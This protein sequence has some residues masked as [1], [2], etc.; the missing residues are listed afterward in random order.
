VYPSAVRLLAAGL[1]A[2]SRG[3]LPLILV[4]LVISN[5]PITPAIVLRLFVLFTLIPASIAW[6]MERGADA[7]V[8]LRAGTLIARRKRSMVEV[9]CSTIAKIEPWSVPFPG[10]GFSLRM[11]SGGRLRHVF[12][13]ADPKPLLYELADRG[14]VESAHAAVRHPV[15]EWAHAKAVVGKSFWDRAV[16]KFVAFALVPATIVFYTKQRISYGSFLGEYYASGLGEW[17]ATFLLHWIT[18]SVYLVLYASLLRGVAESF[19]LAAASVAPLSAIG[20]RR[21]VEL[22]YRILFYGG[23]PA[24]LLLRYSS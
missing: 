20:L 8:M 11:G 7:D 14:H 17:L 1:F 15:V 6:L 18:A 9:P 4:R 22:V 23:V 10:P 13:V 12:Q 24:L 5:P 16:V 19:A 21:A 3:S 2:L